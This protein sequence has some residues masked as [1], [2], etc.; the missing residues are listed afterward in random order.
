[1]LSG[2]AFSG[3]ASAQRGPTRAAHRAQRVRRRRAVLAKARSGTARGRALI[4][5]W[6]NTGQTL[7]KHWANAGQTR[8]AAKHGSNPARGRAGGGV[9]ARSGSMSRAAWPSWRPRRRWC[10]VRGIQASWTWRPCGCWGTCCAGRSWRAASS[11]CS[12][13]EGRDAIPRAGCCHRGP[14]PVMRP[15]SGGARS[16]VWGGCW[17]G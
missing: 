1:M 9:G 2:L 14:P 10:S 7:V 17:G 13:G 8:R 11:A 6:S 12:S 3:R 4:K 16:G 15:A 5:H